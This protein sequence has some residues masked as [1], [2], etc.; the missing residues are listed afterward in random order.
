MQKVT[1][2]ILLNFALQILKV[3]KVQLS[4]RYL[5]E[6]SLES[7]HDSPVPFCDSEEQLL[8]RVCFDK[9]KS[10]PVDEY[11]KQK[12]GFEAPDFVEGKLVLVKNPR[13]ILSVFCGDDALDTIAK[14]GFIKNLKSISFSS[15]QISEF[16]PAAA[17]RIR[18][19]CPSVRIVM[20]PDYPVKRISSQVYVKDEEY[21]PKN[22]EKTPSQKTKKVETV[23]EEKEY[24]QTVEKTPSQ[25]RVANWKACTLSDYT[26][27]KHCPESYKEF[28]EENEGIIDNISEN[29]WA[30][31]EETII[32]KMIV[33]YKAFKETP[34][35]NVKVVIIGQDPYPTPGHAMGLAFSVRPGVKNPP[36]LKNIGKE[37]KKQGFTLSGG[38]DLTCWARQ[39][40]LLLN[41]ALTTVEGTKKAHSKIWT[42]FPKAAIKFI[43]KKK[44]N[45]VYI[46][47]GG[48]ARAYKGLI[49][50]HNLILECA[51]PSPLSET[52]FWNNNHFVLANNYIEENGGTAIDW[53]F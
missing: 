40:V 27:S 21:Q 28:F 2:E 51:H 17:E 33:V 23:E 19:I 18:C 29:L 10:T 37:V 16:M 9:E 26:K 7:T 42:S 46:L 8:V 15:E 45:V 50:K 20:H 14:I 38:G 34:L 22:V 52:G 1:D 25:K 47:W 44:K 3:S 48:D 6:Y 36:S 13:K 31:R 49:P 4:E 30:R 43:G 41:T 24:P 39:G 32:P 53:S 11:L 12:F 35:E 5:S